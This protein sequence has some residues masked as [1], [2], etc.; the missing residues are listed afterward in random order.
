MEFIA[1]AKKAFVA[2]ALAA[3]PVFLAFNYQ[4]WVDGTEAFDWKGAVGAVIAAFVAGIG[5][6]YATNKPA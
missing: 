6:Y 4:G 5:T 3:V 2:G 1:H